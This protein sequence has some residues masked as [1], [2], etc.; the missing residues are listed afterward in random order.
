M[1]NKAMLLDLMQMDLLTCCVKS[2]SFSNLQGYGLSGK[3]V[4]TDTKD[5][6]LVPIQR[7]FD[8]LYV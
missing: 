6:L 7:H 4:Y 5:T 3:R 8:S 2:G 1:A